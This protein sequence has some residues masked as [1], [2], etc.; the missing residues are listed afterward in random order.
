MS[1]LE[2]FAGSTILITGA[3]GFIGTHLCRRLASS[4]ANVHAVSRRDQLDGPSKTIWWQGDLGQID[5]VEELFEAVKPDFVFHLAGYATGLRQVEMVLPTFHDNLTA[6]LNLLTVATKRGCNRLL[7]AGSLE[8]PE[9]EDWNAIPSSPYAAAKWAI[10]AYA[11]MFYALYQTP[12]VIPRIFMVYGP[13]LYNLKKLV[14][15]VTLCLLRNEPPQLSHGEREV[16]WVYI[17]D[18]VEGLLL[19]AQ[20][21][22][23]EG[24][25]LDLGSGQLVRIRTLVEQLIKITQAQAQPVFGALPTRPMEQVRVANLQATYEKLGWKPQVSL[26][27]GL[28]KTVAWYESMI[29]EGTISL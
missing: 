16:D 25:T 28:K 21:P 10:S 11:R 14:P 12:V 4:Q 3:S 15:Y 8:E 5:F 22:G 6:T 2:S 19:M 9:A 29:Q 7:L 27:D 17:D 23:I 13:G 26:E 20:T 18:V 1:T 24:E